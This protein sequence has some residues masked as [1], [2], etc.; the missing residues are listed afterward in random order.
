ML[1]KPSPFRWNAGADALRAASMA[2][3]TSDTLVLPSRWARGRNALEESARA[4]STRLTPQGLSPVSG[5]AGTVHPN[6]T[7]AVSAA[8]DR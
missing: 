7:V 6:G 8:L 3:G 5:G 1:A 4:L 2:S